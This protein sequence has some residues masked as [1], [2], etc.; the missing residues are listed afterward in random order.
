VEGLGRGEAVEV[1]G[2]EAGGEGVAGAD[3][4]DGG[5]GEARGEVVAGLGERVGAGGARLDDDAG[6]AEGEKVVRDRFE[7][8]V[9]G[10]ETAFIEAEE[11]RVD[12]GEDGADDGAGLVVGP[13]LAAVVD[14]EEDGDGAAWASCRRRSTRL[15][16][17]P[18]RASVMPD[19]NRAEASCQ[20]SGA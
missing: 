9:A 18:E 11:E 5:D 17:E 20:A 19:R 12:V 4:V 2:E 13:E 8:V 3:G 14:V 10:Q 7:L 6:G 16:H 15:R 1:G